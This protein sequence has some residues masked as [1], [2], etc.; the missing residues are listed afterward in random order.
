[1]TKVITVLGDGAWGT[2]L[3]QML[4]NNGHSVTLWCYDTT[5]AQ[6]IENFHENKKYLPGI[7][8]NPTITVTTSLEQALQSSWI[9]EAIPVVFLRETLKQCARYSQQNQKWV[10]LSKGI[11]QRTLALPSMILQ[12]CLPHAQWA[13]LLGPSYAHD[14]ALGQPTG[15]TV[16]TENKTLQHELPLLL[17]DYCSVQQSTDC[18][19]IELLAAFKNIL[20]LGMGVIEGA[21]YSD[22]TQALFFTRLFNEIAII[23]ECM[24]GNKNSVLSLAGI[25][26]SI[27]TAYGK[28]SKNKKLGLLLGS[29]KSLTEALKEF[30]TAPESV[31][32]IESA[33]QLIQQKKIAAPL[34]Q[35]L[36]EYLSGTAT[37]KK[38]LHSLT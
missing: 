27:L 30:P 11:E 36:F 34:L 38:L 18:V 25:G 10:I 33:Y 9:F 14:L 13:L 23:L 31:N 24:G 2:A 5:V 4:A 8:L 17:P 22:N 15:F 20:A 21:G 26:D 29:G 19:G 12:E 37:L 16:A 6:T 35:V 3:A 1:M 28:K 7:I 32:T